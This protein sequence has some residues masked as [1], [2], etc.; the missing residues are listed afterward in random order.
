VPAGSVVGRV[1]GDEFVVILPV[2]KANKAKATAL[3]ITQAIA[4][5]RLDLGKR[6]QVDFLGCN[7]GVIGCPES[8]GF[9]D[10]IINAAQQAA[11]QCA[12]ESRGPTATGMLRASDSYAKTVRS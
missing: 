11:Y 3:A 1:A 5:F 2:A 10:E 6:G 8:G 7:I 4:D 12:G 9:A